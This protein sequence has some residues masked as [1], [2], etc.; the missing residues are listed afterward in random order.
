[1]EQS[2]CMVPR[3]VEMEEM[4]QNCFPDALPLYAGPGRCRDSVR[5]GTQMHSLLAAASYSTVPS[6]SVLLDSVPFQGIVLFQYDH[7]NL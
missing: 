6:D 7:D 3:Q 4:A 2:L 5:L 1:M